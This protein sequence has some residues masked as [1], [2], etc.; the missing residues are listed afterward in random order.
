MGRKLF[1]TDIAKIVH[2]SMSKGLSSAVLT[3]I[4]LGARTSGSLT[5]GKAKTETDYPCKG[6]MDK[7]IRERMDGT[8]IAAGHFIVTLIGDSIQSR[9]V[10]ELNDKVTIYD[11]TYDIVGPIGGD[12]ALAT[13]ELE[14]K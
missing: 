5:G 8:V 13:Y 11:K 9:A 6:F 12:P 7:S 10:P 14:V 3:K 1:G 4:T 2:Q